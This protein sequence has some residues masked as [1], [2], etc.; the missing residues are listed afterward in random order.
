MEKI[1]KM[2][3]S[4]SSRN[5]TYSV[6]LVVIVIAIAIV[7]NL[8]A[9]QLPESVRNIDISS[10][11]LYDI[12]SVSTKMLDKLDKKVE[13]KVIAEQDSIDTRIKTFVKKYAALSSKVKVEWVDSVLHPSV[14]QEYNTDGNVIVVSCEST[15]KSTT[16]AFSDIIQSDYYSYYMTGTSSETSF[17]GEG[18]L[19][20]AINYVTSEE[21]NKI[22][23]TSGHGES[24]FSSSVND[25]FTKNNL[26][27]EEINLSMNPE[28]PDDCDLLFLYGPTS[29]I[30]DDEKTIIE[31][32]LSD[33]GKVYLILGDTS[34]E[35]PNLDDLMADYGLKKVSGYIADTQRCYQGNY[36]AIFPQLSLS[37]D[38]G[39]GIS[40]QMVLLL[41]SL[42]MEKTDSDNENL[43][44]TPFMQTSADGYAVTEDDQTQGQYI[45]G[46]I[47]TNTIGSDTESDED[48]EDSSSSETKEARLTVLAS[49]S[50]ISSDITDQL[51]TLDNLTLFVNSVTEN[52]DNVNN[53]AIEAKSLSTETNTPMHAGGFSILVIFIIPLA[54]LIIG[55]VIWMRRRKA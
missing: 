1:R 20:S 30:T 24:T 34:S 52:F 32:Y 4:K 43:T 44:V 41:N 51:T 36:Y 10:N 46:A 11:N 14:L 48:S 54:I 45:L 3:A 42:G 39:S 17:D 29:D 38:L 5:G 26:E 9:G 21:T 50:M 37:G 25:L 47:A 27:T 13:L 16:I 23:R 31:N 2:F 19:T 6:G 35:T 33:G 55:F 12:S 7:I 22:Y 49:G 15:G 18:Q 8:V 53:V 28:I 40:N